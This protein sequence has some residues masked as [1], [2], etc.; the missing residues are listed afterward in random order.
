MEWWSGI[1]HDHAFWRT[2]H[3]TRTIP[4]DR[5]DSLKEEVALFNVRFNSAQVIALIPCLE[6]PVAVS[7]PVAVPPAELTS[8][9]TSASKTALH[10]WGAFYKVVHAEKPHHSETFAIQ[11]ARDAISTN[12]VSREEVR[13]VLR[14]I[15][16]RP[17]GA[18]KRPPPA[19]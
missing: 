17:R 12:S 9:K 14:E 11:N 7:D 19:N 18:P 10:A 16:P 4:R 5:H 13:R 15:A 3:A 1:Q 2:G 8:Q 6:V